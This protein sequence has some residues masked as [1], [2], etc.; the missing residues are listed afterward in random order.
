MSGAVFVIAGVLALF[1]ARPTFS[2]ASAFGVAAGLFTSAALFIIAF[3][4]TTNV[5]FLDRRSLVAKMGAVTAAAMTT[6]QTLLLYVLESTPLSS[7][8][9]PSVVP[10]TG[11]GAALAVGI[12]AIAII[13][14][15][16][17]HI[18][19]AGVTA[20]LGLLALGSMWT[21]TVWLL[22]TTATVTFDTVPFIDAGI[23]VSALAE[24]AAGCFFSVFPRARAAG[25]L[26]QKT[27]E[28]MQP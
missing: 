12:A 1:I 28:S 16:G 19:P 22:T 27:A 11:L 18:L 6:A 5:T 25:G 23:F 8:L 26:R 17:S 24:I 10:A 3:G 2:A 20:S 4:P 15:P 7:T 9:D 14:R 13:A 21:N